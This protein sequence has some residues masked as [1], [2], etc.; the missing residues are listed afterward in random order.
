LE[1]QLQEDLIAIDIRH[2]ISLP[3]KITG[4][5][6]TDEIL[7]NIFNELLYREVTITMD[8]PYQKASINYY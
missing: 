8:Y 2:A 4:E 1:S 6:T 7:D 5:I 3:W